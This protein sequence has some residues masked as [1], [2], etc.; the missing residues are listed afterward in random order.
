MKSFKIQKVKNVSW[1]TCTALINV[2][3][4]GPTGND[5]LTIRDC[6][7]IQG[8]FGSFLASP[9]LKVKEPYENKTTGKMVEYVDVVFFDKDIREELN[10]AAALAYDPNQPEGQWYGEG[11]STPIVEKSIKDLITEGIPS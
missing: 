11:G 1:G 6:K 8:D 7:L 5:L 10:N 2:T 9:S 3:V 4:L